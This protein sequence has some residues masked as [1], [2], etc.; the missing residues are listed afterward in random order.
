MPNYR[1]TKPSS[2]LKVDRSYRA[3]ITDE[4]DLHLDTYSSDLICEF[5]VTK[6]FSKVSKIQNHGDHLLLDTDFAI[7]YRL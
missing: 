6:T 1:N 3:N 2:E 7:V 5:C 4:R